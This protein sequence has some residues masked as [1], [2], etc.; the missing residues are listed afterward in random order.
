MCNLGS[1]QHFY[2]TE[3][4][5]FCLPTLLNSHSNVSCANTNTTDTLPFPLNSWILT[6]E[7]DLRHE[8]SMS[9]DGVDTVP[10][11]QVPDLDGVVLGACGNVVAV[12]AEVDAQDWLEMTLHEHHT[13]AGAKVPHTTKRIQTTTGEKP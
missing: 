9:G 5:I 2:H 12:G 13:A 11:A 1:K 6:L 10:M 8:V 3:N 7:F 4:L